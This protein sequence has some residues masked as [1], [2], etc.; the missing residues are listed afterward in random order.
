VNGRRRVLLAVG[1]V[2]ALALVL[3]L[4]AATRQRSTTASEAGGD[5]TETSMP[6]GTDPEN[7]TD[8]QVDHPLRSFTLAATGDFLLHTP[9][10]RQGAA[11]VG[12]AGYSF[13]PML[14]V[15]API[16]S[17]VDLAL[18]HMETPISDDDTSLS[19]YP[20]FNVPRE[21]A[22]DIKAVGYDGCDT[23]SNHTLDKG[24]AGIASTLN[25]LDAAGLKHTGSF[26]SALE[27]VTP[28]I[29]DVN[30]IKVGHLA[31]AY[32]TNGSPIP[33][34]KPWS[35]NIIDVNKILADAAAT[36]QAGADFVA[37]SLHWGTEYQSAPTPEQQ[38]IARQ[39]LASPDIDF[40]L[41]DHAHVVQPIEKIG[42]KYVAYG[43]GNFLSN[44]GSPNTPTPSQDG[45]I[46]QVS[47]QEQPDGSFKATKV[48][49]TP[50]WVDRSNFLV[51]L[52]T[53]QANKASYDRTVAAVTSLGPL[54]YQGE[55]IFTA[56]KTDPAG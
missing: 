32:G 24:T 28:T 50:T 26:R 10:Q 13:A 1:V 12:G 7:T 40:I 18:C 38:A 41:G 5:P 29:Y 48:D 36:K 21:I 19:G 23:A 9:V 55:P 15:T 56:I 51:T 17:G 33:A 44:Q 4:M 25:V 45:M 52:A 42:D 20:V 47:V 30:G 39:L 8:P 54:A 43:M 35:L 3:G 2:V 34:D 11:N 16:I 14:T 22:A 6:A 53:Q 27:A 31:Y 49:Y 46:L 37:V